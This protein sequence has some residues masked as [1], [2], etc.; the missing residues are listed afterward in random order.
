MHWFS[1]DYHFDHANIIKY[2]NRPFKSVEEMNEAIIANHNACVKPDDDF[3]FL[4]DFV[5]GE[6]KI[7]K[8]AN[9][10]RRL[11]GR[12]N[13][14][15]GNHDPHT[16]EF[17]CMFDSYGHYAEISVNKQ[18]IVLM[19]YAMRIWNKSHHGVWQLY[20]HS[21]NTLPDDPTLL[22]FD[23]GVDCHNFRPLSFDDVDAIMKKK[24]YKPID[25]HGQEKR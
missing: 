24:S 5:F 3:W 20:G 22:S 21:H 4:G 1:S 19:H 10:L 12:K 18:R 7:R 8:G 11:N 16:R 15:F 13:L 23:A 2:A 25:H 6:N 14:I 9:F 17:G